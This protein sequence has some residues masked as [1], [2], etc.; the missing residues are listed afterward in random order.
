MTSWISVFLTF[1]TRA[2]DTLYASVGFPG[3]RN[4]VVSGRRL[5]LNP[6]AE[7]VMPTSLERYPRLGLNPRAHFAG[8][9]SLTRLNAEGQ[10]VVGPKPPGLSGGGVWRLGTFH[11]LANC[12]NAEK[13][14]D[15][16]SP[17]PCRVSSYSRSSYLCPFVSSGRR[18]RLTSGI[19]R[20]L[21]TWEEATGAAFPEPPTRL[22]R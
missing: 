5:Q 14:P 9:F 19:R 7:I 22:Q 15:C 10:T 11:E 16:D 12:T 13:L 1:Q 18:H 21:F 3:T 6:V 8:D 2:A 17:E 20:K 4:R